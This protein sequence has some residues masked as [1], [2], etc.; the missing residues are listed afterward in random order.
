MCCKWGVSHAA[1]K[2]GDIV[3]KSHQFLSTFRT[4]LLV[5]RIK[6]RYTRRRSVGSTVRVGGLMM[7]MP[8]NVISLSG[9]EYSKRH[10][11]IHRYVGN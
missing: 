3:N 5:N 11:K 4:Q 1:V 10:R 8:A 6:F 7:C 9:S 2:H